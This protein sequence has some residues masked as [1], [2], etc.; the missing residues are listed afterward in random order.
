MAVKGVDYKLLEEG[1]CPIFSSKDVLKQ[2]E[3]KTPHC[4]VASHKVAV[5][6]WHQNDNEMGEMSKTIK[7]KRQ[8]LCPVCCAEVCW[9]QEPVKAF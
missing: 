3:K 8:R 4:T 9:A 5:L 2:C 7:Q 1:L 6:L